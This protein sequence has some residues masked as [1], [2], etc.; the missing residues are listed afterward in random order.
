MIK[1]TASISQEKEPPTYS[2][3]I[4]AFPAQAL[5]GLIRAADNQSHE[6]TQRM[7]R[8]VQRREFIPFLSHISPFR[9]IL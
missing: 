8:S 1:S 6:L 3:V 2:A 4:R 5:R 7:E 9:I